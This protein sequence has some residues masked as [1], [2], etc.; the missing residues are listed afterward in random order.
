MVLASFAAAC[1]PPRGRVEAMVARRRAAAL[2]R[3]ER[4][5][6]AAERAEVS[7]ATADQERPRV[8]GG[9]GLN[10]AVELAL[11]YNLVL[12]R[13]ALERRVATGRIVEAYSEAL[14]LLT[15][16]YT[17][18]RY[19]PE[20]IVFGGGRDSHR[21][22]LQ[23]VQ[24]LYKG[25]TIAAGLRAARYFE[26]LTDESVRQVTQRTVVSTVQAYYDV[27][28][29]QKL[30]E[31]QR[32]SLEFARSN[33]DDV[34]ALVEA[35]A[36]IPF[37]LL[38]AEV[39]VSN[40]E[41][42]LIRQQNALD[43]ARTELFRVMGVSQRSDVELVSNAALQYVSV[44]QSYVEAVRTAFSNRPE[45]MVGELDV[46]LQEELLNTL[47]S[48]YFPT[49]EGFYT[50]AWTKPAPDTTPGW[51][52]DYVTGLRVRW[53]LFDGLLREGQIIQQKAAIRQRKISLANA[54][55]DVLAE[56]T[57]VLLEL[58]NAAKLV[59]SQRLNEERAR[60]ALRLVETRV[61]EGVATRLEVLDARAAW[62]RAAGLHYEALHQ[63]ASARLALERALGTLG[64]EDI[65]A[66]TAAHRN[67]P[68]AGATGA[69]QNTS[70]TDQKDSGQ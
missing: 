50:H 8:K 68:D 23:V 39:E 13:T 62:T 30:V 52:N 19:G 60:E 7:F 35:E 34:K 49:V 4:G 14:P 1:L 32:A 10:Q 17:Y 66:K 53:P 69:E 3:W 22:D 43:R 11:R 57:N 36:G 29:A 42:D 59:R 46:R 25:G 5:P 2:N 28:L 47:E 9:L 48:R 20:T 15:A 65:E 18:T 27:L 12:Q 37:D 67:G 41:A 6:T 55:Q 64:L 33:R 58:K 54:E 38:R 44:D 51:G 61:K 31:V 45:L 24:P 16:N 21:Y 70:E 26:V 63:H 40:V 56:L